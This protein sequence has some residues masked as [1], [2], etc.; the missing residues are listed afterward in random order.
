MEDNQAE[1]RSLLGVVVFYIM[2]VGNM[3][4]PHSPEAKGPMGNIRLGTWVL[5]NHAL[6]VECRRAIFN[7]RW[8]PSRISYNIHNIHFQYAIRGQKMNSQK[9]HPSG[10][11]T[12]KNRQKQMRP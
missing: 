7:V 1:E 10:R 3:A 6:A 11:P 12:S 9:T 8:F 5:S 2:A 4:Q